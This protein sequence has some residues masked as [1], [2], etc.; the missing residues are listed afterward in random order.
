[1]SFKFKVVEISDGDE[2]ASVQV[3]ADRETGKFSANLHGASFHDDSL[4]G[5]VTQMARFAIQSR[6]LTWVPYYE[7]N[8]KA[9]LKRGLTG[10]SNDGSCS[11]HWGGGVAAQN[12]SERIERNGES[13][14]LVRPIHTGEGWSVFQEPW[15]FYSV[16]TCGADDKEHLLPITE[17]NR[18]LL[19][20]LREKEKAVH[21]RLDAV[22]E[23]LDQFRQQLHD[24]LK[25]LAEGYRA[26]AEKGE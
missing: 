23:E 8:L 25:V 13:Y 15:R 19:V 16:P 7:L 20:D 9:L 11:L 17:E 5:L 18:K 2:T 24:E 6:G 1:M 26:S 10:K 22:K 21:A 4:A 3:Y 14:V 12:I